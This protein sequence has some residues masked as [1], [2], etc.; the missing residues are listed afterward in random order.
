M[1]ANRWRWREEMRAMNDFGFK[2]FSHNS[3]HEIADSSLVLVLTTSRSKGPSLQHFGSTNCVHSSQI[4]WCSSV[5]V[6]GNDCFRSS[7]AIDELMCCC[8]RPTGN[9]RVKR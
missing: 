6:H 2:H 5:N 8:R 3:L 4:V 9:H 7:L 1:N